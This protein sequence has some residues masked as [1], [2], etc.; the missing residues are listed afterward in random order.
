[1]ASLEDLFYGGVPTRFCCVEGLTFG[2]DKANVSE[3]D[4]KESVELARSREG[5]LVD[6][7]KKHGPQYAT[8]IAPAIPA[9]DLAFKPA[10]DLSMLPKEL[11]VPILKSIHGHIHGVRS[12]ACVMRRSC[13]SVCMHGD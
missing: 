4:D 6:L 10:K 2:F 3:T 9:V 11:H 5:P 12:G 8:Q 1:M 13:V 7:A